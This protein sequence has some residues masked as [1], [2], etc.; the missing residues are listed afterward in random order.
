MIIWLYLHLL[1]VEKLA[2]AFYLRLSSEHCL[3]LWFE[4][5]GSF[6]EH[7]SMN[8]LTKTFVKQTF[9]LL[10][11][12]FYTDNEKKKCLNYFTYNLQAKINIVQFISCSNGTVMLVILFRFEFHSFHSLCRTQMIFK[13]TKRSMKLITCIVEVWRDVFVT[14]LIYLNGKDESYQKTILKNLSLP[15]AHCPRMHATLMSTLLLCQMS[16]VLCVIWLWLK[17]SK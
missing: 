1:L 3:T 7:L 4:T 13:Q 16:S 10:N 14:I 5:K 12:L 6:S 8:S 2:F 15:T 17:R 9:L 11:V